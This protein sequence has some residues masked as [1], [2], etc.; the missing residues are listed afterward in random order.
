MRDTVVRSEERIAHLQREVGEIGNKLDGITK[1]LTKQVVIV[2]V[3]I[4]GGVG[5]SGYL[6]QE[7]TDQK[8]VDHCLTLK[9]TISAEQ[10]R[11]LD[12]LYRELRRN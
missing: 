2:S 9:K 8:I 12:S 10:K 1:N 4:L 5:G 6:G 11:D 7:S 3:V